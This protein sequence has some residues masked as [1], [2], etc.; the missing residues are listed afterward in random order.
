MIRDIRNNN[1]NNNKDPDGI[2][3]NFI[4]EKEIIGTLKN[5]KYS[6]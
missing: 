5:E 4:F 3:K 6:N 2:K 1:N